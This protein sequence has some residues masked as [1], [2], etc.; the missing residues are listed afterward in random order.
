MIQAWQGAECDPEASFLITLA[1]SDATRL[2][3]HL[4]RSYPLRDVAAF[5]LEASDDL[6][7][8]PPPNVVFVS[9]SNEAEALTAALNF[10]G[11]RGRGDAPVAVVLPDESTGMA[12]ALDGGPLLKQVLPFG[13][14][15]NVFTP[16]AFSH[17]MNEALAIASHE[18][19]VRGQHDAGLTIK[20]GP[21][22]S[23]GTSCPSSCASRTG[24]SPTRFRRS[25]QRSAAPSAWRRSST[26]TLPRSS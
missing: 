13:L 3:E 9:L 18:T 14:F 7:E 10:S 23:T 1:G 24:C 2:K 21:S 8:R 19:H 20:Q 15:T 17:T 25:C 16:A 6:D 11:R 26:H 5:R 4:L 12:T 22:W